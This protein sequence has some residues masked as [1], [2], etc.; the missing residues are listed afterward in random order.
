MTAGGDQRT[1]SGVGYSTLIANFLSIKNLS[2]AAVLQQQRSYRA[3]DGV[4]K[5]LLLFLDVRDTIGSRRP[6]ATDGADQNQDDEHI[7]DHVDKDDRI[8]FVFTVI[9]T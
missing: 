3:P 8:L 9:A 5:S 4:L 7:G 1:V 2:K 6:S